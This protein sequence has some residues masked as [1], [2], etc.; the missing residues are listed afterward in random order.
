MPINRGAHFRHHRIVIQAE[1][2]LDER[3]RDVIVRV[4]YVQVYCCMVFGLTHPSGGIQGQYGVM[5]F[6]HVR[7]LSRLP[8]ATVVPD[9]LLRIQVSALP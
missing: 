3:L 7:V 5:A 4:D 1:L 8:S 2:L 9:V 6:F